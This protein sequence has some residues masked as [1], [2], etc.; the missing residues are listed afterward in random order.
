MLITSLT[1]PIPLARYDPSAPILLEGAL[2]LATKYEVHGVR[3]LIVVYLQSAW[4]ET[5]EDWLQLRKENS[6]M[7]HKHG[8]AEDGKCKG[9]FYNGCV[10]EPVSTIRMTRRYNVPST[11]PGA[12]YELYTIYQVRNDWDAYRQET[13]TQPMLDHLRNCGR[14][15]RR[16]L[17]QVDDFEVLLLMQNALIVHCAELDDALGS[18]SAAFECR[19]PEDCKASIARFLEDE[20]ITAS[21]RWCIGNNPLGTLEYWLKW[22]ILGVC[23]PCTSITRAKMRRCAGQVWETIMEC[24]QQ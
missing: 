23:K 17:L 2:K 9:K 11:L 7:M 3:A 12:Y 14:T 20:S 16:S 6:T 10:P 8:V 5:H 21:V 15:I 22:D 24:C 1:R 13:I 19:K 18:C 4:P